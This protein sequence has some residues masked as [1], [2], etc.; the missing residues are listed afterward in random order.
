M[1]YQSYIKGFQAWLMLEKSLLPNSREA[2]LSD[3]QKFFSCLH[4]Q[5]FKGDIQDIKL[6][7]LQDLVALLVEMGLSSSSQSRILSGVR[8]FF[9]YCMM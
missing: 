9:T 8:S 1:N 7:H 5:E 3:I 4:S 6:Q 2:Y